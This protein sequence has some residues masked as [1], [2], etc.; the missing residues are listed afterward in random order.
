MNA[1]EINDVDL[2]VLSLSTEGTGYAPISMREPTVSFFDALSGIHKAAF[3]TLDEDGWSTSSIEDLYN[4]EGVRFF[5]AAADDAPIAFAIVRAVADEAEL[6]TIVSDPQARSKGLAT[7]VLKKVLADL[8]R[9]RVNRLFLE[10][11]S[12]N[13]PAI[14]LYKKFGFQN[15]GERK[16][17]YKTRAG[18]FFDA[19]TL[20]KNI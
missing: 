11:R 12:D 18:V 3:D 4:H 20:V 1:I 9:G 15:M 2:H 14:G 17:Y 8:G 13:V 16:K 19:C 7:Q 10:V 5:V 6:L